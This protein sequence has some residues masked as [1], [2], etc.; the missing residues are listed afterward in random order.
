ML[1]VN[2]YLNSKKQSIRLYNSIN[3]CYDIITLSKLLI[4]DKKFFT[5]KEFYN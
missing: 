3:Y 5:N 1:L 4:N 2:K